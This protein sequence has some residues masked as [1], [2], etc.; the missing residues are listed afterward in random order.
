MTPRLMRPSLFATTA[1][2][3]VLRGRAHLLPYD[4]DSMAPGDVLPMR[5]ERFLR[6]LLASRSIYF[7]GRATNLGDA[8]LGLSYLEAVRD[9]ASLLGLPR[10]VT[11]SPTIAQLL[12]VPS[13][14]NPPDTA[15][16]I[17]V[18]QGRDGLF[19]TNPD[20]PAFRTPA[21]V[22]AALPSRYYLDVE[23]RLG[24]RLPRNTAFLP[25]LSGPVAAGRVRPL[26]CYVA[27]SSWPKR[28]DYGARGYAMVARRIDAITGRDFDHV[29]I[30]GLDDPQETHPPLQTLSPESRDI[31]TLLG[32]FAE[33]TLVIGNDTGLI[34]AAAMTTSTSRR[35]VIGIYGR[36]SYLRFTTGHRNQYAIATPFAQAMAFSDLNPVRDRIDD[37]RYRRAGAVRR[38]APEYIAEC[39]RRVLDGE[40]SAGA[41]SPDDQKTRP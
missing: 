1:D 7:D 29:L 30:P 27:A 37:Q 5:D 12:Q 17:S 16:R 15:M 36:H 34:H 35:G 39:A 9:A 8:L 40:W 23:R 10:G 31:E 22:Y 3:S 11:A 14:N 21:H 18:A 38:I 6:A 13:T 32:L 33:A 4:R 20:L 24:L 2:A 25:A 41:G 19:D 26:L 28:K